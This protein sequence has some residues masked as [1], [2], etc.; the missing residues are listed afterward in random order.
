MELNQVYEGVT[1]QDLTTDFVGT[2]LID[3]KK[4]F[5]DNFLPK[6]TGDV[7]ITEIKKK[8]IKGRVERLTTSSPMRTDSLCER[9][10]G[11]AFGGCDLHTINYAAQVELKKEFAEKIACLQDRDYNYTFTD[12]MEAPL[13]L[14]YRNKMHYQLYTDRAGRI[15]AGF[16]HKGTRD[17]FEANLNVLADEKIAKMLERVLE[18]LNDRGIRIADKREGTHG[19]KAVMFRY[20]KV[21]NQMMVIFIASTKYVK[22]IERVAKELQRE[23]NIIKSV[24]LNVNGRDKGSILGEKSELLAGRANIDDEMFGLEML[25]SPQSF[26]QVNT[27]M[28]M[29]LYEQIKVWVSRQPNSH[30]LDLYT[31]TGAI[32]LFLAQHVK[33]V[34]GVDIVADAIEIAQ[35]NAENNNIENVHFEQ[36]DVDQFMT[37]YKKVCD[38]LIAIIDP[39]RTG[40][41]ATFIDKLVEVAPEQIIYISCNPKTLIRDLQLLRAHGYEQDEIK[42]YD[43]FPET[44]HVES[45]VLLTRKDL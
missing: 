22:R 28:A 33:A 18:K 34:T 9:Y 6:E 19:L 43:M 8:Y 38:N 45:A 12:V 24:Y 4:V 42:L 23:Q 11:H 3:G 41:T 15:K 14:H 17:M 16:Y 40:C 13:P 21:R 44:L 7:I 26:Y 10:P 39:P 37:T 25:V 31:G 2:T 32:A 36:A 35:L 27:T 30:V 5:I 1:C 29:N 20:S